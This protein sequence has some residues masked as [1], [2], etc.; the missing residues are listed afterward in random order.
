M[1]EATIRLNVKELMK[2]QIDADIKSDKELAELIGVSTTQIWRAKLKPSHPKY[3]QPGPK[4]IAGILNTFKGE[5]FER[6]FFVE[7]VDK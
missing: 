2:A 5:K 4:L 1:K 6:F 3:N 7:E